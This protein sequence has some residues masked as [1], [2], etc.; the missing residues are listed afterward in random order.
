MSLRGDALALLA[1]WPAPTPAQEALRAQYVDYLTAHSSGVFREDRPHHVTA[2]T[3]VLS[4]DASSVLL[5]LHAKAQRWFQFGGHLEPDDP[6]VLGAASREAREE[7]GL[8]LALDPVP[9]QLSDHEVPFCGETADVHHLDIR[10]V[11]IAPAGDLPA[12]SEESLD[13][14]WW[15][16]DAL[17]DPDADLVELVALARGRLEL[18]GC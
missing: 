5:T 13:V 15:P 10:F 1:S 18:G 17:P 4:T 16:A 3:L 14:R 7:S 2:S 12:V 11:A 6:S 8:L 9:V